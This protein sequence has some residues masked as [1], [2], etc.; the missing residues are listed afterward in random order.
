VR[1]YEPRFQIVETTEEREVL[2]WRRL[3][4]RKAGLAV[5]V[6]VAV[7]SLALEIVARAAAG[8]DGRLAR[9]LPLVTAWAVMASVALVIVAVSTIFWWVRTGA[10]EQRRRR[11][12]WWR[13]IEVG[14]AAH[15]D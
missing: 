8:V 7:A 5:A 13:A 14:A 11:R 10:A 4:E 15:H 12:S 6:A 1:L 9:W 3:R 2:A